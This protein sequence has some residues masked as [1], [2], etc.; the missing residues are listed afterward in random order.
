VPTI[1]ITNVLIDPMTHSL[2]YLQT[3]TRLFAIR[4]ANEADAENWV[5]A[6]RQASMLLPFEYLRMTEHIDEPKGEFGEVRGAMLRD[7]MP[8]AVKRLHLSSVV[9][10]TARATNFAK[11]IE[12]LRSLKPHIGLVEFVGWGWIPTKALTDDE[13]ILSE[14]DKTVMFYCMERLDVCLVN[15]LFEARLELS[16]VQ[17]LA[18]VAQVADGLAYLHEEG[19]IFGDLNPANIM[20]SA[21]TSSTWIFKVG[22]GGG[23]MSESEEKERFRGFTGRR[24]QRKIRRA[25]K[26][27]PS[28]AAYRLWTHLPS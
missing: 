9:L 21:D 27:R 23:G 16:P 12:I 11:E 14:L 10:E 2:F 13:N 22:I 15:V 20:C 3:K 28:S 1:S 26:S 25:Y 5:D 24:A 17:Q 4:A 7:S 8:V 18:C 6:F 19:L